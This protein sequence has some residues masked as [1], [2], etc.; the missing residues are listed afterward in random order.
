M[1]SFHLRRGKKDRY[2]QTVI[3]SLYESVIVFDLPIK[4]GGR[5]PWSLNR[6]GKEGDVWFQVLAFFLL[7]HEANERYHI[8]GDHVSSCVTWWVASFVRDVRSDRGSKRHPG[9]YSARH[10][11]VVASRSAIFWG[12][13]VSLPSPRHIRMV[14]GLVTWLKKEEY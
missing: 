10:S 2:T 9:K 6:I 11:P 4:G 13:Q 12:S 5:V 8:R 7:S 1:F 14:K 3:P